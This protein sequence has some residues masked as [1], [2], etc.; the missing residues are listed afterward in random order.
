MTKD[1]I[2]ARVRSYLES[3]VQ[4]RGFRDNEDLFTTGFVNSVQAAELTSFIERSFSISVSSGDR[5]RLRTLD[6][7][8]DYVHRHTSR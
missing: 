8:V 7:I 4:A 6:A 5:I 2:R 3:S 1:Q